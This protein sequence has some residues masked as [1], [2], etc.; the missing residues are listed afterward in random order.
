MGD[1]KDIN[2][3]I[4]PKFLMRLDE[5]GYANIHADKINKTVELIRDVQSE[6]SDEFDKLIMDSL[7]II[8]G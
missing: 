3:L 7:A 4:Y 8:N 6:G 2:D 1:F 5:E